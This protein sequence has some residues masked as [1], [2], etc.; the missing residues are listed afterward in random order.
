MGK[1]RIERKIEELEHDDDG[2]SHIL[3]LY[4]DDDGT[5]RNADGEPVTEEMYESATVVLS[6]SEGILQTWPD[7]NDD[8]S[9]SGAVQ[10]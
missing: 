5:V 10:S 6:T 9:D 7:V 8:D 3:I 4:E 2:G 1:R